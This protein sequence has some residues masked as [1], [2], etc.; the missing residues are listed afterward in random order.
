MPICMSKRKYNSSIVLT[1][2][3][4]W[5]INLIFITNENFEM[6]SI[7]KFE[8]GSCSNTIKSINENNIDHSHLYS[9][10]NMIIKSDNSLIGINVGN[11]DENL[12]IEDLLKLY[13]EQ[14]P[15]YFFSLYI[16]F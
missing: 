13:F 7:F 14:R 10:E 4:Y 11:V 9:N 2:T 1:N 8:F 6:N 15:V 3:I 12:C 16:F 5:K